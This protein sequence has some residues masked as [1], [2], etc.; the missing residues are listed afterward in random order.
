[1]AESVKATPVDAML[2]AYVRKYHQGYSAENEDERIARLL[3]PISSLKVQTLFMELLDIETPHILDVGCGTGRFLRG[4]PD[5]WRKTGLECRAEVIE[6]AR[7]LGKGHLQIFDGLA[8]SLPFE[9]DTFDIVTSFQVLEHVN[10]PGQ[11]IDEMF[12]VTKPGGLIYG[13]LPNKWH[14]REPHI[15]LI[16]P[17]LLPLWLRRPYIDR[18]GKVNTTSPEFDYLQNINYLTPQQVLRMLRRNTAQ[19]IHL[20]PRR[21][22]Q[23]FRAGPLK[24]IAKVLGQVGAIA[25]GIEFVAIK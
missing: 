24:R 14:P 18:F 15:G 21:L 13:E 1:M 10:D 6:I 8:E 4:L 5:N 20:T 22:E 19:V 16:Y 2:R 7:L 12:R 3:A 17:Q 11:A 25:A 9:N 23:R